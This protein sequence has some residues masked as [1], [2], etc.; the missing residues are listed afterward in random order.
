MAMS[1]REA[2]SQELIKALL[3]GRFKDSKAS[4]IFRV[5]DTTMSIV[6][7]KRWILHKSHICVLFF[8]GLHFSSFSV[9]CCPIFY[10]AHAGRRCSTPAPHGRPS[11]SRL[12][13]SVDAAHGTNP[14][15][16]SVEVVELCVFLHCYPVILAI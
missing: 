11:S 12:E 8:S 10:D 6:N 15:K 7:L 14:P 3:D 9:P 1:Q 16:A 2:F 4:E 13:R 5:N